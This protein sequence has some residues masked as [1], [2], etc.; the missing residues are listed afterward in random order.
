MYGLI[1]GPKFLMFNTQKNNVETTETIH[2]DSK[3]R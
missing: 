1:D 2:E 3:M